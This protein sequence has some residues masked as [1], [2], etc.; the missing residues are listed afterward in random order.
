MKLA[1]RLTLK[2]LRALVAVADSAS[3]TRRRACCT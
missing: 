2:Q 3:F 1:H